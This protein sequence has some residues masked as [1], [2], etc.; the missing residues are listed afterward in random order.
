MMQVYVKKKVTQ[1]VQQTIQYYIHACARVFGG[2]G[3]L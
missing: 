3:G 1:N 2:P